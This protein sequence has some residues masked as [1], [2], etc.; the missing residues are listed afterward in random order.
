M[1]QEALEEIKNGLI[2]PQYCISQKVKEGFGCSWILAK[3]QQALLCAK[4]K[5]VLP[6]KLSN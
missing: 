3:L 5:M 2:K 6:N 4:F 1:N